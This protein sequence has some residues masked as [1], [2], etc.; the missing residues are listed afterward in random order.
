M[1][2][3][4]LMEQGMVAS[5]LLERRSQHVVAGR[6]ADTWTYVNR[7]FLYD[8]HSAR[9]VRRVAPEDRDAAVRALAALPSRARLSAQSQRARAVNA[10]R[11]QET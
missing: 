8:C 11:S 4:R 2:P 5:L 6:S 7:A 3:D 1:F 9:E 10:E